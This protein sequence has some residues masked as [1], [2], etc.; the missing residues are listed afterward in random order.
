MSTEKSFEPD[1]NQRPKDFSISHY[2]PPLYQLSYRRGWQLGTRQ[3][4]CSEYKHQ[5]HSG[6]LLSEKFDSSMSVVRRPHAAGARI[7]V[8]RSIKQ[9]VTAA[10]KQGFCYCQHFFQDG[11][12]NANCI[13]CNSMSQ[14]ALS[15]LPMVKSSPLPFEAR[16]CM[17]CPPAVL[18]EWGRF[19]AQSGN[20]AV[21]SC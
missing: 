3:T 21:P 4:D 20:T 16:R 7:D 15:G 14:K 9:W 12:G 11:V 13:P 18:P 5:I 19:P 2:S 8:P 10:Q 6:L 17:R 1:L